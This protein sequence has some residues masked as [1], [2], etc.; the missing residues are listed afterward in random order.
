M[1]LKYFKKKVLLDKY[2][3]LEGQN[4]YEFLSDLNSNEIRLL[5]D[6][7]RN[8]FVPYIPHYNMIFDILSYNQPDAEI[9]L[10]W[11]DTFIPFIY[12][13]VE[14]K[15]FHLSI[16][17]DNIYYKLNGIKYDY[18]EDGIPNLNEEY[19][20]FI[21]NFIKHK[22]ES[23]SVLIEE[24]IKKNNNTNFCKRIL[25]AYKLYEEDKYTKLKIK[26]I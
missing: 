8:K 7:G 16:I 6:I 20:K 14:F 9:T 10:K 26:Y 4:K 5:F 23:I 15:D 2:K 13:S 21:I 1:L 12:T 18:V 25:E 11:I 17:L 24:I 3:K 22:N 19:T